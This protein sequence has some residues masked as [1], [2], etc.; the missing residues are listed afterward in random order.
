[1]PLCAP[2]SGLWDT[3]SIDFAGHL[4]R[5]PRGNRYIL[6]PVEHFTRWPIS[7]AYPNALASIVTTFLEDNIF[8]PY[9]I[10]KMILSDSGSQF[11]AAHTVD[12][13]LTHG[14]RWV[15]TSPYNPRGNGRAERMIRTLKDAL[16]KMIANHVTDW[17]LHLS[18]AVRGYRIRP[19]REHPSPYYLLFGCEPRVIPT[20]R[21]TPTITLPE[22]RV[23]ETAVANIHRQQEL[24]E[25]TP[26]PPPRYRIGDHVLVA[27]SADRNRHDRKLYMNWDG[28][29]VVLARDD[30]LYTL[31]DGEGH[32]LRHRIHENRLRLYAPAPRDGAC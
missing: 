15:R 16:A 18:A 13:A 5:T 28:S 22:L 9:A 10:P 23:V 27:R 2:I 29:F 17:D 25:G 4:P 31:G 12:F 6:V 21:S 7:R 8:E 19:T 3:V 11:T 24:R 20:D 14:I 30:L 26:S 1:M 32:R